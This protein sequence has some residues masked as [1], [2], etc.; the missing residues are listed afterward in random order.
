LNLAIAAQPLP[1][2][3]QNHLL[4]DPWMQNH[5]CLERHNNAQAALAVNPMTPS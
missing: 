2:W 1:Q 3:L 5:A 4:N